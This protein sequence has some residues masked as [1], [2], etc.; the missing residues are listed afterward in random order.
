MKYLLLFISC[1]SLLQCRPDE[2]NESSFP[3]QENSLPVEWVC[4]ER[5]NYNFCFPSSYRSEAYVWIQS[6]PLSSLSKGIFNGQGGTMPIDTSDFIVSPFPAEIYLTEGNKLAERMEICDQGEIIGAYY[7]G[8]VN[9]IDF[10]E[11][12]GYLYLISKDSESKYY[13]SAIC[14]MSKEGVDDMIE[15]VKRIHKKM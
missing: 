5:I 9:Y 13:L 6:S 10:S 11:Y 1:L 4:E 2:T 8:K 7:Y 3:C 14:E 15:V 12:A